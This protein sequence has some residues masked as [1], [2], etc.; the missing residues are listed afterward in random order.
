[1]E[2]RGAPPAEIERS[3]RSLAALERQKARVEELELFHEFGQAS[4]VRAEHDY[5]D[6]PARLFN[7]EADEA[8]VAGNKNK[9]LEGK[10]PNPESRTFK[11][12]PRVEVDP[13]SSTYAGPERGPSKLPEG[14]K[15]VRVGSEWDEIDLRLPK[16]DENYRRTYRMIEVQDAAGNVV[17][18][19]EEIKQTREPGEADRWQPRGSRATEE[20]RKAE[21]ASRAFMETEPLEPNTKRVVVDPHHSGGAGFDNASFT[22]ELDARGKP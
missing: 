5:L 1:L 3:R 14:Q 8:P 19:L 4:A 18:R 6:K 2:E 22:F 16:S 10:P 12:E 20:G 21:S 13:K 17:E 11:D 7:I 15:I 9:R